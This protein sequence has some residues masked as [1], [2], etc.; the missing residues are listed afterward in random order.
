MSS[1]VATGLQ[2][3]PFAS[4]LEAGKLE[5][6][7][8]ILRDILLMLG[9]SLGIVGPFASG[10]GQRRAGRVAPVDGDGVRIRQAGVRV[11]A[12]QGRGTALI[13]R[14]WRRRQ[15]GDVHGSVG[16]I[17]VEAAGAGQAVLVRNGDGLRH[18]AQ[19]SI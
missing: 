2:Q 16:G 7:L 9:K 4:R 11:A 8:Q 18:G 15:A 5:A 10:Q 19:I 1:E 14:A 17:D 13:N 3:F 12:R 6:L